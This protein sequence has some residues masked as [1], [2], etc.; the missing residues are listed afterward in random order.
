MGVIERLFGRAAPA[1]ATS[2]TPAVPATIPTPYL[3]AT[4]AAGLSA[5]WRCV[6]LIADTVAGFPWQEWRGDDQLDPSRLVRRPMATMSRREWTWRVV[7]TEAL[8]NTC[9]LLHVGGTDSEGTPWSLLP[10][11]PAAIFPVS[12]PDPFGILP[13]TE[14]FVAGQTVSADNLT[15]VRRAP[16]PGVPEHVAGILT[17]ARREFQAFLAA[18]TAA[19][20]YWI[21]GGPTTTVITTDQELD[22][23]Q[24]ATLANR[25]VARR[26]QGSEFPAVL[27]KGAT[28]TPWGADPTAESAVEARR[29][30]VA[31]IGRY[32]GVPTRILNAPA[33]DSETYS[34]VELDGIDLH[35]Y[36]LSG[37]IDP[38]E[39]AISDN[40]PGDRLGGRRMKLD[41]SRI[42]AGPLPERATAY[43]A[44]VAAGIMT[45]PEVRVRGF[46]LTPAPLPAAGGPVTTTTSP[47]VA[48]TAA[49]ATS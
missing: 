17:L 13:P 38:I 14:Y 39:D 6:S 23:T 42:L 49:M 32:F 21:A 28:A 37:Y 46:G 12:T 24:A 44:L 26:S 5:V 1:A 34:N 43:A 31:D 48:I 25:W 8:M 33:G 11:P 16:W 29:E 27:G 7:A 36:T 10:V 35:R 47:S 41:P 40:L 45:I 20:R 2:A 15:L 3:T 4:T 22:D 19:A 18:D 9:Y 30:M